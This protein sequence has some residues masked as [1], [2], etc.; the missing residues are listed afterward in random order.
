MLKK[1]EADLAAEKASREL[2]LKQDYEQRLAELEAQNARLVAEKREAQLALQRSQIEEFTESLYA[3]GKLTDSIADQE[4]LTE[5]IVGLQNNTLEFS[6]GE[7][8]SSKL[9]QMLAKLPSMVSYSE[10]AAGAAP[11]E[12]PFE[13]LDPHEKALK[14][15]QEQG[16][17]YAEALKKTLFTVE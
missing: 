15:S 16:I 2:E 12:L 10:I 3:H 7:D 8:A 17:D 5:Y 1:V 9:M 13:D 14:L 11:K 6:E 4:E